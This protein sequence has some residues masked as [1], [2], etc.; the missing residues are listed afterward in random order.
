MKRRALTAAYSRNSSLKFLAIAHEVVGGG[1]GTLLLLQLQKNIQKKEEEEEKELTDYEKILALNKRKIDPYETDF[2]GCDGTDYSD[3]Y[4]VGYD[5]ITF[6][7]HDGLEEYLRFFFK[8]II[9]FL[10]IFQI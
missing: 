6:T 9:C 3:Y 10:I 1:G 8:E 2:D 4:E 5:G 7:F